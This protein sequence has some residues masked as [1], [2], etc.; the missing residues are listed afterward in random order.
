MLKQNTNKCVYSR[1]STKKTT[2]DFRGQS[3]PPWSLSGVS[4]MC[5]CGGSKAVASCGWAVLEGSRTSACFFHISMLRLCALVK[6]S[7]TFW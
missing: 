3:V 5:G 1:G 2:Q 7:Q 4:N 6:W